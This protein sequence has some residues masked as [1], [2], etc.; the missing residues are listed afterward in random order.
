VEVILLEKVHNLG[1]LGDTVRVKPGYGRN[2]LIPNRIAIPATPDNVKEIEAKRAELEAAQA[3]A[4]KAAEARAEALTGKRAVVEA[5][6]GAEGKLFGSVGT[7]EIA[8][9]F[10]AQGVEVEKKEV[11]LPD[12]PLREV[13]LFVVNLHLFA[14]VECDVEVAVIPEGGSVDEL[15]A[16]I[17]AAKAQ[18]EAERAEDEAAERAREARAAAVEAEGDDDEGV[19]TAEAETDRDAEE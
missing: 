4:R 18:A 3:E 17:E 19:V 12:G 16:R 1:E 7:Q 10:A 5:R 8:A 11:R 2:F 9:S 15:I 13:G 6:A 14:D